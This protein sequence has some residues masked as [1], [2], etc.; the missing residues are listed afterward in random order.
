MRKK[1]WPF[2]FNEKWI[3]STPIII[4]KKLQNAEFT[5]EREDQRTLRERAVL[6]DFRMKIEMLKLSEYSCLERIRRSDT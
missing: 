1:W 4:P 2:N 5:N 3:S 6:Q